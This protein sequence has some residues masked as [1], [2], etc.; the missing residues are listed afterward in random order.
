MVGSLICLL[1]ALLAVKSDWFLKHTRK[2]A[3]LIRQF[4]D[5]QAPWVVRGLALSGIVLGLLLI[6]EV[7]RPIQW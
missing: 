2:G 5:A 3:F 6:L 4:G 7:V 1:C